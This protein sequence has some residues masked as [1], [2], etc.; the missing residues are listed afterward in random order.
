MSL[1]WVVDPSATRAAVAT[2]S[3]VPTVNA[4]PSA[5][6]AGDDVIVGRGPRKRY[7]GE[8]IS[9]VSVALPPSKGPS[10]PAD[11]TRPSGRSRAVEW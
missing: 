1:A 8:K 4:D 7:G 2:S 3:G 5:T 11:Q 9:Y 6:V 10:S